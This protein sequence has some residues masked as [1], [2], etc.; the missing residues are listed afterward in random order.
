[1]LAGGG[2]EEWRARLLWQFGM[3]NEDLNGLEEIWDVCECFWQ[4]SVVAEDGAVRG[5]EEAWQ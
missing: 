3:Q 2:K 1:M 4:Q 5:C